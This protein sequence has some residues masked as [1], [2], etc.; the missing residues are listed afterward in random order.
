[1][2][3]PNETDQHNTER[4]KIMK[5]DELKLL[6]MS[7]IQVREVDW[8]WYPYIPFGKLTIIH[9]DPGEG[10]TTFAL[11]L[12]AACS[13]GTPLPNMDTIA[14]ITVIYQSAEDGLD[15]TVKPRLIEA[16]ADQERIINIC[17]EEKSLHGE[18]GSFFSQ[19]Q[20][21]SIADRRSCLDAFRFGVQSGEMY[22]PGH[23]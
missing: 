14:P 22:R 15:D 1:M 8:L 21:R 13:T 17:E 3:V 4:K 16:G 9:G 5:K 2:I 11:R 10:K 23:F 12:A 7:D 6:K 20:Y 18:H 19:N